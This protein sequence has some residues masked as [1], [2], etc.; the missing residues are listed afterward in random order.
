MRVRG[1]LAPQGKFTL[2]STPAQPGYVTVRFFEH[3]KAYTETSDNLTISGYEYDEYTM[4]L[5]NTA[6]LE[7]DIEAQYDVYLEQAKLDELRKTSY[8]PID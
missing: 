5:L 6:T 3:V 8:D 2:H 7:A 4:T 1:D